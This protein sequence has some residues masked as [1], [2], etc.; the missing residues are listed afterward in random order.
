MRGIPRYHEDRRERYLSADEMHAFIAALD[1]YGEENPNG[2]NALRLLLL[3]GAREGEVLKA[4]WTQFDL[5]RAVRTKPSSHTKEKRTEHVSLNNQTVDVLRAIK[6][7]GAGGPLFPGREKGT[8]VTL[9][10]AWVQTCERA[11]LAR[12]VTLKGKRRT[13]TRYKPLL[14]IH[15][16]RHNFASY[17]LSE[18][19]SLSTVGKLLGHTQIATTERYAHLLDKPQRD[20][21]NAFGRIYANAK[22]EGAPNGTGQGS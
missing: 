13:I 6:P 2:A 3:T 21:T 4:D 20:A 15:D 1:I 5:E 14:R 10:R 18:G 7:E 12:E 16:L 22:A 8:R 11:G 19:A 9:R 17:V